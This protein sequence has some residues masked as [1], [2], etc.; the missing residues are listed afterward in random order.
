VFFI[1]Y[2]FDPYIPILFYF[3]TI[4]YDTILKKIN[5]VT[6]YHYLFTF[7]GLALA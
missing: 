1:Y 5:L 3:N 6:T 2:V 4:V 7:S